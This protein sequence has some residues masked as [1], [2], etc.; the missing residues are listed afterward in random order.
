[1][2]AVYKAR[3]PHLDRLVALKILP[4]AAG[5]DPAFAG[6][7]AREARVLARLNHPGIVSVHDFG[8]S[9]DYFYLIMEYVDGLDLRRLIRGG[10][11][12]GMLA[13]SIES[14][15]TGQSS[16]K[17]QAAMAIRD[18]KARDAALSQ[19][20]L[21]AASQGE[22]SLVLLSLSA[23]RDRALRDQTVGLAALELAKAGESEYALYVARMIADPAERDDLLQRLTRGG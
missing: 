11:S 20:L 9:G 7:F 14:A 21:E 19:V 13:W 16:G 12:A 3:Q 6:R 4:P 22:G 1:M 15:I 2:G 5:A 8:R 10:A 18:P 23:I 17:V